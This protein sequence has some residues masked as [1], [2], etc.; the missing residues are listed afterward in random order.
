MVKPAVFPFEMP[1][2]G[3]GRLS[4]MAND[5]KEFAMLCVGKTFLQVNKYI[6][7]QEE[8]ESKAQRIT[9]LP[10]FLLFFRFLLEIFSATG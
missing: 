6:E 9:T 10:F 7:R 3:G 1:E 4:G 8:Y 2:S 5:V